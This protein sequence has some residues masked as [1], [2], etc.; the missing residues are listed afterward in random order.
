MKNFIKQIIA[1]LIGV[2]L[3]GI[4]MAA[5]GTIAVA[6][7]ILNDSQETPI[8]EKSILLISLDGELQECTTENPIDFII[9]NDY[10]VL[11]LKEIL[12]AIQKAKKNKEIKGIYL[13]AGAFAA[14]PAMAEEIRQELLDFK[15]SGKF[16]VAYGDLYTQG[17]YYICS[18]ADKVFLNPQGGINWCGMASQPIFYKDL[19]SKLGIKMQVF[20]VGSYKSAVEPFTSTEMSKENREQISSYLTSIWNQMLTDISKSRGITVKNLNSY[21]DRYVAFCTAEEIV[22]MHLVDTICYK[23]GVKNY[24]KNKIKSDK[25]LHLVSVKDMVAS[26]AHETKEKEAQIAIYY[27]YGEISNGDFSVGS[28][29]INAEKT[30]KELQDLRENK[31]VKAVV[32]RVNSPGGSAYAS[33]QIWHEVEL[34]KK[35]KP[36]IVSMGGMAASGGYYISCGANYIVTEPMTLTGSIGIF[37]MFPDASNLLGEKLE[38]TFDV[39]K[40]N[41]FADFGAISRPFNAAE[42]NL[43]QNYINRGYKLF[44]NRVAKGRNMD[45]SKVSKLAEGRVWTGEQAV[46]NGLADQLGNLKDAVAIAARHAKIKT[47]SIETFPK[48]APWFE[49]LLEE[50]ST[51][52]LDNKIHGLLG[53]YHTGFILLHNINKTGNIQARIPFEPNLTN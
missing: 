18:A 39:V 33:E 32:L 6:A 46:K 10:K 15:K 37:G 45:I 4:I 20:K 38:L 5:F 11:D 30:C 50:S 31:N 8:K 48:P 17:C 2:L 1:S 19:L 22:E 43:L 28:P 44:T 53:G 3:A 13:E 12:T 21:A 51:N 40:T 9:R 47:Y 42:A 25:E 27:A 26:S 49:L 16:V 52:Y 41:K 36:V 34:L 23:D 35:E 29:N 24:L 14:Q 7:M